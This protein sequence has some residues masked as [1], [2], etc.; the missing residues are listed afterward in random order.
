M[1]TLTL[2]LLQA[3][4]SLL[5]AVQNSPNANP[6][7]KSQAIAVA[8]QAVQ[9]SVKQYTQSGTSVTYA[10]APGEPGFSF[11]ED[12]SVPG[13]YGHGVYKRCLEIDFKKNVTRSQAKKLLQDLGVS[14]PKLLSGSITPHGWLIPTMEILVK[15]KDFEKVTHLLEHDES[16][17]DIQLLSPAIAGD[18]STANSLYILFR[19]SMTPEEAYDLLNHTYHLDIPGERIHL[20]R[21]S[22]ITTTSISTPAGSE[23]SIMDSLNASPFIETAIQCPALPLG[24]GGWNS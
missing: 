22:K 14:I 7:L 5:L 19:D 16:I 10:P 4:L 1:T 11:I 6:L 2:A 24:S 9:V 13:K 23:H 21:D 15:D 3:T 12:T 18:D 8:N 17:T 20:L